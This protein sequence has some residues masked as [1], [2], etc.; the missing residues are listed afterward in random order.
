MRGRARQTLL[1]NATTLFARHGIGAVSLRRVIDASGTNLNSIHYHFGSREGLVEAVVA[2]A[3]DALNR[4]RFER[5]DRL[6]E[7]APSLEEGLREVIEAAY[8]P[9]FEQ[10][11]SGKESDR[12][13][14]L[15]IGQLRLDPSEAARRVLHRHGEDFSTRVESLLRSRISAR[16]QA[17]REGMQLVSAAGWDTALRPDTLE[18]VREAKGRV[19]RLIRRFVSFST[20]G[21]IDLEVF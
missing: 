6:S 15:V 1:E 19:A 13:G 17:L 16:P 21:L 4:E 9:L 18:Y 8:A 7:S 2:D 5:F 10:A 11:L 12:N 3:Y 20:S 14:L